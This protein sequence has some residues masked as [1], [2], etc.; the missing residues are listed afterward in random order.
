[1]A[2]AYSPDWWLARLIVE[3]GCR[4]KRY[5]LLDSY[6]RSDAPLPPGPVSKRRNNQT[7]FADQDRQSDPFEILRKIARVNWADMIVEALIERMKVLGFSTGTTGD[8]AAD[9][10]AWRIW[11][12]NDLD[13]SMPQLLRAKGVLGDAYAIVGPIDP[14]IEAPRITCED[15]R[16]VIAE[17]DPV[18]RRRVVAALKV[19]GDDVANVDR[20]YLYL[21]GEDGG[22][23][24]LHKA[25]RTRKRGVKTLQYTSGGWKFEPAEDLPTKAVPVVWF[26]NRADLFGRV[27]GEF[28]HVLDDLNRISLLVL[29]R[30]QIAMLQ[31]FRQ[32]AVK[33]DLPDKDEYGKDINYDQMF[34]GDP[35]AVWLL[36]NGVEMWES[37]GVDLTPILESVKADVRELAG[38]TRTPLYYLYPDS[39][40][41]AEGAVTQREGLIFRASSRITETDGPIESTIA[42]ALEVA[43]KDVPVDME[44]IWQRPDLAT[45][46]ERYDA[47]SKAKAAGLPERTIWRE[48]LQYSPTQITRI[49]AENA[50]SVAPDVTPAPDVPV[51]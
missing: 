46:A 14:L 49:E 4:Q 48:I 35:A 47:A 19:F 20:A 40:G 1:M 42:L 25:V 21:P 26:P 22:A 45:L 39:G 34:S 51:A 43:G 2:D 12:A 5:E 23:A 41:S 37:S 28:E 7:A 32:R 17:C 36:P 15:P 18:D 8:T 29:Q 31:A 3:L 33:G 6:H 13:T 11:Q 9:G 24:Q 30:L 38:R 27:M 50:A 10:E 16:Q 44:T